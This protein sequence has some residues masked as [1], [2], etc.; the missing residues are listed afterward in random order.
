MPSTRRIEMSRDRNPSCYFLDAALQGG[1]SVKE[2]TDRVDGRRARALGLSSVRGETD[3]TLSLV[4]TIGFI[5]DD[6]VDD[7]SRA[8][9][10]KSGTVS[11]CCTAK[12]EGTT[13]DPAQGTTSHEA[14]KVP[15]SKS[16]TELQT[17]S[18]SG[19]DG[20]ASN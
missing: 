5:D 3:E 16:R 8:I 1:E 13:Y 6:G 10:A 2:K 20:Q 12:R 19:E 15:R 9:A 14:V 18:P 11:P 17:D 4:Q 7:G